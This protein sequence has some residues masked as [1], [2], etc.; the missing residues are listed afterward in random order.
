MKLFTIAV[1]MEH[2]LGRRYGSA[3][4]VRKNTAHNV[5]AAKAVA[6]ADALRGAKYTG[7]TATAQETK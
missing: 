7:W 6:K 3:T 1:T 2:Q 4:C 5:E